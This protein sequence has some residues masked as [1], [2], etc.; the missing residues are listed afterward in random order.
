MCV[1]VGSVSVVLFS[2]ACMMY[3]TGIQIEPQMSISREGDTLL[4]ACSVCSL[5][6]NT[7]TWT[8]QSRTGNTLVIADDGQ[9]VNA[10]KYS[11]NQSTSAE[12]LTIHEITHE[13]G[14]SYTCTTE[15]TDLTS[16]LATAEVLVGGECKNTTYILLSKSSQFTS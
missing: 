2:V 12:M 14:G 7:I 4:L 8:F 1:S 6:N 9:L 10:D 13:D 5:L 15:S 11:L 16:S 3:A